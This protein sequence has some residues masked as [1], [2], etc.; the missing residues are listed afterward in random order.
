MVRK[1][2]KEILAQKVYHW[3]EDKGEISKSELLRAFAHR[4]RAKE[5]NEILDT[6]I[7]ANLVQER[8]ERPR[9]GRGKPKTIYSPH[10][11]GVAKKIRKEQEQRGSRIRIPKARLHEK[12][13]DYLEEIGNILQRFPEKEHREPPYIYDVVWYEF[14]EA[15]RASHVFEIQHKGDL[16]GALA[17]LQHAKDIWKSKPF[18]IVTGEKDR[19]KVTQLVGPL[20]RGTFHYLSK[21]LVVLSQEDVVTLYENLSREKELLKDLLT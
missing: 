1:P 21:D 8:L 15:P 3:I 2:N 16:S 12:L 7:D 13:Q 19:S 6:L 10:P 20:L 18:L 9:I 17:K 5:M 4:L 11:E 14:L